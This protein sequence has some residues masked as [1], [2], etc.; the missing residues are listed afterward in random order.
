[1]LPKMPTPKTETDTSA[2]A[3][4]F[5]QKRLKEADTSYD[6]SVKG[7]MRDGSETHW[8]SKFDETLE[9]LIYPSLR[10]LPDD[11]VFSERQGSRPNS[12]QRAKSAGPKKGGGGR[13]RSDTFSSSVTPARGG[14]GGSPMVKYGAR[15]PGSP[16][17]LV[18]GSP[19]RRV[20]LRS[21][22]RD[23]SEMLDS[24]DDRTEED[25]AAQAAIE[26]ELFQ[27]SLRKVSLNWEVDVIAVDKLPETQEQKE[28][29][30]FQ[31]RAD[32]IGESFIREKLRSEYER[33]RQIKLQA[34]A[35]ENRE[36]QYRSLGGASK[37]YRD[38][39]SDLAKKMEDVQPIDRHNTRRSGN[40]G[41]T[42]R[43]ESG[44]GGNASMMEIMNK[45]EYIYKSLRAAGTKKKVMATFNM[46]VDEEDE[47]AIYK[48]QRHQVEKLLKG[49][50]R[51]TEDSLF[52]MEGLLYYR[53]NYDQEQEER[54]RREHQEEEERVN[55]RNGKHGD[56][57]YHSQK[58]RDGNKAVED[59]PENAMLDEAKR[60][61][62]Y[63]MLMVSQ[64][65]GKAKLHSDL[66]DVNLSRM[67]RAIYMRLNSLDQDGYLVDQQEMHRLRSEVESEIVDS[68]AGKGDD[69]LTPI[70]TG[71]QSRDAPQLSSPDEHA[72]KQEGRQKKSKY[73]SV[74]L[75]DPG[76]VSSPMSSAIHKKKIGT[77]ADKSL[78]R[79]SPD[80]HTSIPKGEALG[81][82][83]S[84]L[85]EIRNRALQSYVEGMGFER[86]QGSASHAFG[87]GTPSATSGGVATSA[88]SHTLTK[89]KAF[90]PGSPKAK[91]AGATI[92]HGESVEGQQ[93]SGGLSN[94]ELSMKA[95]VGSGYGAEDRARM[96]KMKNVSGDT[97][98][99]QDSLLISQL[100]SGV[101][102]ESFIKR[103][104]TLEYLDI[105]IRSYG[106]GDE[107]GCCLGSAI[108]GM[109][110]LRALIVEDNRL[111]SA[112]VPHIIRSLNVTTLSLLDLSCNS[113]SNSGASAVADFL[114][115]KT[116]LAELRMNRC[117]LSDS[118][119][120]SICQAIR[121]NSD[122]ALSHLQ[123]NNNHIGP[124]G[125]KVIAKLLC[126][127]SCIIH[128]MDI[129]WNKVGTEGAVPIAHAIQVNRSVTR[130]DLSACSIDDQGG[131]ALA[132][133]LID[134]TCMEILLLAQN[135]IKGGSCFVF[136]KTCATHPRMTR[137][138]LSS[139]P[140]GEA[141]ARSVYRQIMRGLRCFV[142]MRSCSYFHDEKIFNYTNPSQDSPY[143][144]D[145]TVPY[146]AA[147][148]VE[149]LHLAAENPTNCRFGLVTYQSTNNGPEET[150]T[151]VEKNGEVQYKGKIYEP[152][153]KG[154]LHV[155]FFSS[156]SIPSMRNK[157]SDKSLS[158]TKLIVRSAAEQDRLPYLRLITA[159][160]HMTCA[161]AQDLIQYF[162]E[163]QI[164]GSGGL[165]KMDI[166][167][168]TWTHLIDTKNM[169]D[170][171]VMNIP[172]RERRALIN[173]VT[174]DEF[175]FNWTNP[176]GHWRLNLENRSQ[177]YVMLK[178]IAINKLESD[179]SRNESGR[180]DTSQEGNWFNFRN[181]MVVTQ[182][183]SK[184]ITI[185]QEFVDNLPK[186]GIISFDYVSTTR[187][188]APHMVEQEFIEPIQN[189]GRERLNADGSRKMS[190][191]GGLRGGNDEDD[192]FED[193]EN[194]VADRSRGRKQAS[195][196]MN[197]LD[198]YKVISDGDF[199]T[200][201]EH[202]GLSNR[203]R[204]SSENALFTLLELQ[205]AVTK[206]WFTVTHVLTL[207]D[208]FQNE[209]RTQANVAILMF[210]R[211]KDLGNMD[212]VLRTVQKPV[213]RMIL[214][215]LGC[216]NVLNPLKLALD[217][218]ISM[219]YLDERIL[220]TTLLEIS[221]TEG[222]EQIREDPK[223]DVSV[224]TFYGALHR[225]VAMVR[226]ENLI[227]TYL[228]TGVTTQTI[229][230]ALRRDAMRKFLVG[231][232]PIDKSLFRVVGMHR[233]M[234]RNGT[235]S[236]G[237]I[238]LQYKTHLKIMKKNQRKQETMVKQQQVTRAMRSSSFTPS[239]ERSAIP[240]MNGEAN[241]IIG[242]T[243][244]GEDVT[245]VKEEQFTSAVT[246]AGG[247]AAAVAAIAAAT[248]STGA[249]VLA[250]GGLAVG[251]DNSDDDEHDHD[252]HVGEEDQAHF[253]DND[254]DELFGVIKEGENE[255]GGSH[256][257]DERKDE[258][259]VEE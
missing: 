85:Q 224:L 202:L 221:P 84:P 3:S 222:T 80:A 245:P 188:G 40:V 144:L 169:Y 69:V 184:D 125:A 145:L 211:I 259:E 33:E 254:H 23:T 16:G 253:D 59:G 6:F 171:M 111:T 21:K 7:K 137:L 231:T 63:E 12:R 52:E 92:S 176:T 27:R 39:Q 220:L 108:L 50:A 66:N 207:I 90:T 79:M 192:D 258:K 110:S 89:S 140:V 213:Q 13:G 86:Y 55:T 218:R 235:L 242:S 142:Q 81:G 82:D 219:L 249:A 115:K 113:V 121:N 201:L 246:A 225:I 205:L 20:A 41:A 194:A 118:D 104:T 191:V 34:L 68:G 132:H 198:N 107:Q 128:T 22:S 134:N 56:V 150:V 187:P 214:K 98:V 1:M 129:S 2:Y 157:L 244:S 255:D 14:S 146:K 190:V 60:K 182:K 256:S 139:N 174:I 141:G 38:R 112:S 75:N 175:K 158:I 138:D 179:Y 119:M 216:L 164:I 32:E 148:M 127:D 226:D 37:K 73:P 193:T 5:V 252:E 177:L 25:H 153:K 103:S 94:K 18:T 206:Y 199:Y 105:D 248:N 223:T 136:S 116:A 9:Y 131:Q 54:K 10:S 215:R 49:S 64:H 185:D 87:I 58:V 24:E 57:I 71:A 229:A 93:M 29:R 77:K 257:G 19:G 170:F 178:L 8:T 151:L 196:K 62:E 15:S 172:K 143:T 234:E 156:V 117:N 65:K 239:A 130:L 114:R 109:D 230:W 11:P 166:L 247:G 45:P 83:T 217:Y 17:S 168:C 61:S 47:E 152:P 203:N 238:E 237:P 200:F 95:L 154:V 46:V 161:Q 180:G 53:F 208:C 123:L 232:K 250:A 163:N 241:E 195:G 91:F 70:R 233:E 126:A 43:R 251:N 181:A 159:D 212:K 74:N 120:P 101:I 204:V 4:N 122:T 76:A 72:A 149:L 165:R 167:A 42:K 160:V 78:A 124:E 67:R 31:K 36:E 97:R 26:E 51:G 228:E 99:A 173:E 135:Q 147:V 155:Q 189:I 162:M 240:S 96:R 106:I 243:K 30:E 35:E 236:R 210:T 88:T 48:K 102:P 133:S 28:R 197:P 100:R 186:S 209:A 183:R 227:F 44:R